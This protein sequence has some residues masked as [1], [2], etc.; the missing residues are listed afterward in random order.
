MKEGELIIINY[1]PCKKLHLNELMQI[2]GIDGNR[3][4]GEGPDWMYIQEICQ[5]W[6]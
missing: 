4:V 1:N 5:Y 3:R 2:E 6:I